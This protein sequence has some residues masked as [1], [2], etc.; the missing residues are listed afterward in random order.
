MIY[1][2]GETGHT[3]FRSS[4]G[5]AHP[6]LAQELPPFFR[7][8]TRET[9]TRLFLYWSGLEDGVA[10]QRHPEWAL[11]DPAGVLALW[12]RLELDGAEML[13]AIQPEPLFRTD[14][15]SYVEVALRQ[16]G[17]DLLVH[18]VNGCGERDISFVGTKDFWVDEIPP[19]GPITCWIR[20]AERPGPCT[21][22]PRSQPAEVSWQNSVL[23]AVLP[24]LEI[25]TCLRVRG[26]KRTE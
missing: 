11:L 19:L 21:W 20:C 24:R 2:K 7:E 4:L 18:F 12:D 16:Q 22:E 9:G 3:S 23:K 1:A 10:G 13:E 6:A 8:L 5:S 15:F 25:H 17:G 14:A 26:W